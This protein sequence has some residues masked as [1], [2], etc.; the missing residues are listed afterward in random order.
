[1]SLKT[2]PQYEQSGYR[3]IECCKVIITYLC[4]VSP[5]HAYMLDLILTDS[6]TKLRVSIIHLLQFRN[7]SFLTLLPA[8]KYSGITIVGGEETETRENRENEKELKKN[9][10]KRNP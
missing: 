2:Q 8:D 5:T 9:K 7:L 10:E 6:K 1:M 3:E 4:L